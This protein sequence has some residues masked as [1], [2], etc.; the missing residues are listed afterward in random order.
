MIIDKWPRHILLAME[1]SIASGGSSVAFRYVNSEKK[2][3][4]GILYACQSQY[5]R[6]LVT[7][8]AT[9]LT[10]GQI[11]E[12]AELVVD[13][14]MS[15]LYRRDSRLRGIIEKLSAA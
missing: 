14:V 5:L 11:D 4:D 7:H 15:L 9:G 13:D 10:C 6:N 12:S 8:Y 1:L 2:G 3:L